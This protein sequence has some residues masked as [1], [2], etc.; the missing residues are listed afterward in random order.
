LFHFAETLQEEKTDK[1]VVEESD[2][3]PPEENY[4]TSSSESYHLLDIGTVLLKEEKV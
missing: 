4:S 3:V 2:K 1:M